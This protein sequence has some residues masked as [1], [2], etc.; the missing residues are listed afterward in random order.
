MDNTLQLFSTD[1]LRLEHDMPLAMHT[2]QP[3][4]IVSAGYTEHSV[5]STIFEYKELQQTPLNADMIWLFA[6]STLAACVVGLARTLSPMFIGQLLSLIVSNFHWRAVTESLT[7]QNRVIGR[8]L[9]LA[10]YV[11]SAV[12]LYEIFI[13]T[14]HTTALGF[15]GIELYGFML[16]SILIYFVLKYMLHAI[17]GFTFDIPEQTAHI[18][19][20][21]KIATG[22]LAIVCFPFA[23]I[24]PFVPE[25]AYSFMITIIVI[26][27]GF[28]YLWRI[29]QSLKIILVDYLSIIYSFLYLCTVEAMP[30]AFVSKLV[31]IGM[32]SDIFI[33]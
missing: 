13:A 1:T 4:S 30:L 25:N 28:V 9:R 20:C 23:M 16:V 5:T 27:V 22:I 19:A 21:K 14:G 7:M 10:F 2:V 33:I 29:L 18:L 17:I 24:F 3:Q 26:V 8:I 15:S 11:V 32:S 12:L 6:F 31:Y